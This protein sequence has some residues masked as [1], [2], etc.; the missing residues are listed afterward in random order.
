MLR[1][2]G[3]LLCAG[4]IACAC[5]AGGM[6]RASGTV[7][8]TT[9]YSHRVAT[10]DVTIY[11]SCAREATEVRFEGVVENARGGG[12]KFIELE[13]AGADSRNR[14]ISEAKTALKD[15]LT[16][17]HEIAPFAI[18]LRPGGGESRFDLF[19]Q[20]QVDSAMSGDERPRFRALDVCSPSQHRF[21]R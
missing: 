11:Y 5:A 2:M 10:T 17:P 12:V 6:E 3:V 16:Q 4:L 13:L 18:R 21:A 19:Y 14:Y 8:P 15:I 9:V 20:Y 1:R 7:I